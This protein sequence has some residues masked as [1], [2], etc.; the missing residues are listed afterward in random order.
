MS[1]AVR[2]GRRGRM[3]RSWRRGVARSTGGA[4]GDSYRRATRRPD[5]RARQDAAHR[6]RRAG[7]ART[8]AGLSPPARQLGCQR[9]GPVLSLAAAD[10]AAGLDRPG[11]SAQRARTGRAAPLSLARPLRRLAGIR[12]SARPAAGDRDAFLRAQLAGRA[13]PAHHRPHA[14]QD[15]ALRGVAAP[16]VRHRDGRPG[17]APARGAHPDDRAQHQPRPHPNDRRARRGR[18]RHP[19]GLRRGAARDR[20][21][22]HRGPQRLQLRPALPDRPRRA[23]R[24]RAALGPRRLGA[25]GSA[26]R[27]PRRTRAPAAA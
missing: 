26:R 17:L 20:P 16:P 18:G 5:L 22:H 24:R 1:T 10:R 7:R 13:V 11:R 2:G 6:R 4:Y 27:R 3:V 21:G 15:D 25:R 9:V 14:L 8:G 19:A 12:R 23:P